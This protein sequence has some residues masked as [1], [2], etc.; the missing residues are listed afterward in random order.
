MGRAAGTAANRA[1][2]AAAAIGGT[3]AVGGFAAVPA[4][5]GTAT[6]WGRVARGCL[7]VLHVAHLAGTGGNTHA[8]GALGN[9]EA[10][11]NGGASLRVSAAT[12]SPTQLP[13]Q[14]HRRWRA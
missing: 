1:S 5:R 12:Y 10:P 13:G 2:G 6:R 4:A 11:H 7:V 8:A 14:Y 9:D 3:A